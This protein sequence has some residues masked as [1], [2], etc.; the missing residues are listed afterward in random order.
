MPKGWSGVRGVFLPRNFVLVY[1]VNLPCNNYHN[2]LLTDPL[3]PLWPTISPPHCGQ[4]NSLSKMQ[5]YLV[6]LMLKIHRMNFKLFSLQSQVL[7]DAILVYFSSLC[8]LGR[9]SLLVHLLIPPVF[10]GPSQV[11]PYL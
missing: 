10:E 8:I 5:F 11:S 9:F 3:F 4:D 2:C 1:I 7:Y 6:T